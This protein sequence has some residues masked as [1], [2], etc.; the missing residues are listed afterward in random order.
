MFR[1]HSALFT[2]AAVLCLGAC[3]SSSRAHPAATGRASAT[4]GSGAAAPSSLPSPDESATARSSAA[5]PGSGPSPSAAGLELGFRYEGGDR[6]GRFS[7]E[8]VAQGWSCPLLEYGPG[9][10]CGVAGFHRHE[11]FLEVVCGL[12]PEQ[13]ATLTYLWVGGVKTIRSPLGPCAPPVATAGTEVKLRRTAS[14]EPLPET[15]PSEIQEVTHEIRIERHQTPAGHELGVAVPGLGW[16]VRLPRPPGEPG[17]LAAAACLGLASKRGDLSL[18]CR[19]RNGETLRVEVRV[20]GRVLSLEYVYDWMDEGW[21]ASPLGGK[22]L[23]SGVRLTARPFVRVAPG[24]RPHERSYLRRC[25]LDQD[26]CL[27]DCNTRFM[28]ERFG[29]SAPPDPEY[30]ACSSRCEEQFGECQARTHRA[31]GL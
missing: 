17:T 20:E 30:D 26:R 14:N 22:D 28:A 1:G 11:E 29:E 16:H 4:V 6:G 19:A 8:V 12:R 25:A 10:R 18:R 7:A 13:R 2:V 31:T 5:A 27:L 24:S 23:P 3:R 21:F 9:E 15:C